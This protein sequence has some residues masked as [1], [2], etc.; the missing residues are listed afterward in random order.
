MAEI[1]IPP[2]LA[3]MFAACED[4]Y[5]QAAREGYAENR[6]VVA[7]VIALKSAW[8]TLHVANQS[9]LSTKG[10][11]AIEFATIRFERACQ[12]SREA[13]IKLHAAIK[14]AAAENRQCLI[15]ANQSRDAEQSADAVTALRDERLKR[16]G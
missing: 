11:F 4:A 10:F 5:E 6:A 1:A 9:L 13:C 8:T 2:D 15:I 3:V 12:A 16:L 7:A 14:E